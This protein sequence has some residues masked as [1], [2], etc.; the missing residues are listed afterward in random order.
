MGISG[1]STTSVILDDVRVP[2]ENVLGEIGKGHKIAF[3]ILNIGRMK[4]GFGCAGASKRVLED[5]LRYALERKQFGK[6]IAQFGM[7]REK[8][9]NM[10]ARAFALEAACYRTVGYIDALGAA[11]QAHGAAALEAIEEYSVECAVVKVAGSETLDYVVDEAVQIYGGYGYC[12]EYPVERYYRDSRINRIFEGTNEINRLLIPAML[13]RKGMK[14]EIPLFPAAKKLQDELMDIP[15]FDLEE[16]TSLLAAERKICANLK[17]IC[18]FTA[19]YAAQKYG[20][21]L[22]DRQE[23]LARAADLAIYAY[24]AESALLRAKKDHDRR[25]DKA[26]LP[27]AAARIVCEEAIAAAEVSAREALA[28]MAEGDTLT[29][30]LAALRRLVRRTPADTVALRESIAARME[31]D[32]RVPFAL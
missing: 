9:A 5:S 27:V 13:L 6:P 19:G 20:Q 32:E 31:E 30:L 22:Q 15:S 29:T 2:P 4:L 11:R 1:S 3:N 14:G 21:S 12:A 28:A 24:M 16:D 23:I 17:K 26:A 8:L 10:Y 25:G 18:L 7:I